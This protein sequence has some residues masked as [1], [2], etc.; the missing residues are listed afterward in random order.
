MRILELHVTG[1]RSLKDVTWKPGNLNVIIGPNGT[2]KSNLLRLLEMISASSQAQLGK[3]VQAAGGIEPLL[4]DGRCNEI[5]IRMK[6]SPLKETREVHRHSLTYQLKLER[7]G[8]NSSIYRIK[9]ESLANYYLVEKGQK[10]EPFKLLER[11][12]PSARIFDRGE[13][14]LSAPE[15][16]VPET[17][18]LLSLAAGPFSYNPEI[19][20]YENQLASWSVYHDLHVNQDAPIRASV[21]AKTDKRVAPNGQNLISVLHTLYTGDR[22]FKR[23]IN[24]AMRAAFGEEFEE[25]VFPP[26]ADQRI[27]LRVRWKSL[28][29]EQS[30]AD[31]SDGTLRFLF[32]LAALASPSASPLIAIDEPETGLHPAMLPIIADYAV[33][34]SKHSQVIITTHSPVILDAFKETVP[35]TVIATWENGQTRLKEVEGKLLSNWLKS[36]SLGKLF[37]S[38]ELEELATSAA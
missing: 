34:A 1:F 8:L 24:S 36:Y 30:A 35:T 29:R 32:L 15:E 19:S 37:T 14:A 3:F 6:T 13:K 9:S 28:K 38:G 23:E 27:Q 22:E 26:A 2:G 10:P 4:W 18:T 7:L 17:E 5:G 11:H 25:L 16:E 21:V 31:L 20:Q 33:E 12:G